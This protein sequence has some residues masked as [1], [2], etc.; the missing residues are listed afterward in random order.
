MG[1]AQISILKMSIGYL[2]TKGRVVVVVGI[3][4]CTVGV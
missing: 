1:K 2:L 4:T 3:D